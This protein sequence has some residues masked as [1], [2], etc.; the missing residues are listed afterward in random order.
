M[1]Q[2]LFV[3]IMTVI[4]NCQG[5]ACTLLLFQKHIVCVVDRRHFGSKILPNSLVKQGELFL[6]LSLVLLSSLSVPLPLLRLPCPLCTP[7]PLT[8]SVGR[9]AALC[10]G[11]NFR[12]CAFSSA[13]CVSDLFLTF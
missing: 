1:L 10:K 6:S 7:L 11:T 13:V 8:Q 5:T 9:E 12:D 4:S 2:N 3:C